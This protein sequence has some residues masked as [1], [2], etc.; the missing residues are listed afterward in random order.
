MAKRKKD[1]E[2]MS[3]KI[4][5]LGDVIKNHTLVGAVDAR[6]GVWLLQHQTKLFM[7]DAVKLTEEMFYQMALKNFANFGYQS[8]QDPASLAELALCALE[9]KFVDDE[10]WDASDGSK[11]EV[12]EKIAE[13]LV[14]KADMLKEYLGVVIDKER[15]QITGVPSMLPG[16]APEIGKLPEFVLALAEDVDWTSEKECFE[17]CARVIGAFFAMDC[18][19]DDPKAEEGDAESDARRVARLCVFPAMKRRLAPPRR[20]A[21]DGTVIQIACLEQLYK[22]FERC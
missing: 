15:R 21:D 8:L 4:K 14:E 19:F 6:K 12:A 20:F 17:T 18:S 7:V 3:R 13:M 11:E 9:D 22:I 16:Y 10:E 1:S 2:D 5:E